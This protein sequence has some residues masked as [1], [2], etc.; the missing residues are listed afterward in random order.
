MSRKKDEEREGPAMDMTPMIDCVFLLLIFFMITTVFKNPAQLKMTLP[1]AYNPAKLDKKQIIVELDA[2]GT[3]QIGG[4]PVTFDSFDSFLLNEK[5]K[6]GDK[7]IVIRADKAAKHGDVLKLMRLTKAVGIETIALS[8]EN[9]GVD[10]DTGQET[11]FDR[12]KAKKT[13]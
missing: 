12:A 6:T 5:Q 1:D 7:S 8:T 13:K 4:K 3:I 11:A 2:E 10:K 9:I